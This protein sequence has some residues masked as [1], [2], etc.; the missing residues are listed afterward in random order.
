MSLAHQYKPEEKLR[1]IVHGSFDGLDFG[2]WMRDMKT[3]LLEV[4]DSN[5][6][7]VD[8][9]QSAA[10]SSSHVRLSNARIVGHQV[11]KIIE[12]FQVSSREIVNEVNNDYQNVTRIIIILTKN[13]REY[14]T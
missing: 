7:V 9:S 8:W 10:L 4:E 12:D 11:A 5:V 2:H 3:R 6:I 14:T 13:N 1:I